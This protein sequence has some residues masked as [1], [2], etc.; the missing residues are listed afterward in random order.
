M[1]IEDEKGEGAKILSVL[2]R[3]NDA[4]FEGYNDITDPHPHQLREI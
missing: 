1:I 2:A 4:R 3:A